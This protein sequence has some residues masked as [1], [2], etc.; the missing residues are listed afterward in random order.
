MGAEKHC[1]RSRAPQNTSTKR[2]HATQGKE[3][4]PLVRQN[5]TCRQRADDTDG[6]KGLL[7]LRADYTLSPKACQDAART[8]QKRRG[9]SFRGSCGSTYQATSGDTAV[10]EAPESLSELG[11][12][13]EDYETATWLKIEKRRE[14]VQKLRWPPYS[15]TLKHIGQLLNV[16][17]VTIFKDLK[18]LPG[19]TEPEPRVTGADGKSYPP[20]KPSLQTKTKR[21][22]TT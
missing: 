16:S 10:T 12:T 18:H 3:A 9:L 5:R 13:P 7:V 1:T 21:R 4:L 14:L 20:R 6:V 22:K 17:L 15:Y 2:A 19:T 8:I 11:V